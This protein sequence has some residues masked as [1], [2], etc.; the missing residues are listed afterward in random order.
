MVA[1]SGVVAFSDKN[2]VSLS[3][4]E[5]TLD[6]FPST[7]TRLMRVSPLSQ[8]LYGNRSN[9]DTRSSRQQSQYSSPSYVDMR[10]QWASA[11]HIRGQVAC[12]VRTINSILSTTKARSH[13]DFEMAICSQRISDQTSCTTTQMYRQL[14]MRRP[15]RSGRS[16]TAAGTVKI[17]S[18]EKMSISMLR[19]RA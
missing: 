5:F 1:N 6:T 16:V 4:P 10:R 14:R 19:V 9:S 8:A 2:I 18:S 15:Y 17:R 11:Q 7:A 12:S 3:F 13:H